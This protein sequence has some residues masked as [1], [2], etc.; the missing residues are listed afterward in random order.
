MAAEFRVTTETL[1]NKRGDLQGLNNKFKAQLEKMDGT[2]HELSGM[3]EGDASKGFEK[4][5]KQDANK[6]RQLHAA[7]EEY[8][9]ALDTIIKQYETAEKKNVSIASNRTY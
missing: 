2:Q 3:W 4:S 7:V 6:M 1:K 9:R 5:Y 8:C